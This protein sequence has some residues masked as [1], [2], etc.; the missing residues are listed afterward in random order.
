MMN[1]YLFLVI[2]KIKNNKIMNHYLFLAIIKIKNNII[3]NK[4]NKK[5]INNIFS[6]IVKTFKISILAHQ[7]ISKSSEIVILF[8]L[9]FIDKQRFD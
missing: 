2:I 6:N 3:M 9:Y 1:H 5:I 4:L 7:N 8:R